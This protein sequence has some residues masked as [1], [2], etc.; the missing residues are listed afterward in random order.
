MHPLRGVLVTPTVDP[1]LRAA[2]LAN[3]SV[4]GSGPAGFLTYDNASSGAA[5]LSA[6]IVPCMDLRLQTPTASLTAV[7][8]PTSVVGSHFLYSL[9]YD[10]GTPTSNAEP[11]GTIESK[12][13][14]PVS[15]DSDS[16]TA[17]ASVAYAAV[18]MPMAPTSADPVTCP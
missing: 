17:N 11:K 3:A 6:A 16:W 1:A 7:T 13:M 15:I 4:H 2:A 14:D 12:G 18:Y 5:Y 10:Y 8:F 9:I